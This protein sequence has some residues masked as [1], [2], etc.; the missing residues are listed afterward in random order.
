MFQGR[1][2]YCRAKNQYVMPFFEKEGCSSVESE[3]NSVPNMI[4]IA[5]KQGYSDLSHTAFNRNI[6]LVL[7]LY[8]S[9]QEFGPIVCSKKTDDQRPPRTKSNSL[10]LRRQNIQIK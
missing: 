5:G 7:W 3:G 10:N 4:I 8:S 1:S 6:I 9:V 2:C